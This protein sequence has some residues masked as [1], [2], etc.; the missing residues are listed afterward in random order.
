M[1]RNDT[2]SARSPKIKMRFFAVC[3]ALCVCGSLPACGR[4]SSAPPAP[5]TAAPA[6]TSTKGSSDET[7]AAYSPIELP[8]ADQRLG[9]AVVVLIDTSGS[10]AQPVRDKTGQS[11][12]KNQIAREAMEHIVRYTSDWKKQHPD[13]PLFFGL[14]S[15]A[16]SVS[17]ILPA[18]EFDLN[19]AQSALQKIPPPKGGTAI[20][21]GIEEGFKAL[22]RSGC[23]RKYLVCI[24]DGENTAGP[25]PGA[26]AG[27]LYKQTGGEVEMHF[28]AFDTSSQH[29][30]FLKQ[31]NGHVVEA[32]D[33]SQLEAK[34]SE[35]YEKR[36]LAEAL[37]E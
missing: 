2:Y 10:M 16:D 32:A 31:V 24:T 20:G 36:I 26:V 5:S 34:L 14:N 4:K 28:V 18:A 19:S 21:R 1:R 27:Q 30:S 37:P 15:F 11:R 12:P 22:Y 6:A 17:Q 23:V 3:L 13:S 25:E 29:F 9:T 35:I 7:G 33:G 8:Q